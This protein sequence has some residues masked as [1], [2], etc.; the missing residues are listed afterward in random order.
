[1]IKYLKY[2][3]IDF[4]K[5]DACISKA[6][7]G[8]IYAYS[9][10]LNM[11]S[12]RWEALVENDYERVM[13]LTRGHKMGLDYL[14]Q[15][16]FTQQLGVFSKNLL[17]SE[18]V[19][20][21]IDAIPKKYQFIEINLNTLNNIENPG[22]HFHR[23][24]NH[25]LDLIATYENIRNSYSQNL[26]RNLKKASQA[27]LTLVKNIKPENIIS[28]FR[29]NKGKELGNLCEADYRL[30]Q[31]MIYVMIYKRM[32]ATYGICDENNTLIA[33]IFFVFSHKKAIFYFSATNQ[34]ARETLAMP[35]LIDCFISENSGSHLTLDFEGSNNE[36]L[37][38][39]YKSFG[40]AEITYLHY[41]KNDMSPLLKAGLH[42]YKFF[43]KIL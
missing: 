23:W 42:V 8:L 19:N 1:M 9:W 10:Y 40:A 26:K 22:K 24:K 43:R 34:K 38:R 21:F 32:A 5:W 13:P 28:L 12:E 41:L 4:D 17:T 16:R 39:F 27:K 3:E 15:P 35:F 18:I 29:E 2:T 14:F 11:V 30:L 36:N 7:N 37:A 20:S 6:F 33:G 31:R 25:E